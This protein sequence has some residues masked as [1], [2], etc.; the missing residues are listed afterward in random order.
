MIEWG[1]YLWTLC[2]Y[3]FARYTGEEL[4]LSE[5]NKKEYNKQYETMKK[6]ARFVTVYYPGFARPFNTARKLILTEN[7]ELL[8]KGTKL[9]EKMNKDIKEIQKYIEILTELRNDDYKT[10]AN[11]TENLIHWSEKLAKNPLR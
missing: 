6:Y 11:Q 8:R 7:A 9:G 2:V 3:G 10:G 1:I 5:E 4:D